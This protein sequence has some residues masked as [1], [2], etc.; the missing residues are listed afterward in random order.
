MQKKTWVVVS[1]F[2]RSA[3]QKI[4]NCNWMLVGSND[5]CLYTFCTYW[6]KFPN[7]CY[8]KGRLGIWLR[9]FFFNLLNSEISFVLTFMNEYSMFRVQ[10]KSKSYLNKLAK[11]SWILNIQLYST[12]VLLKSKACTKSAKNVGFPRNII[13]I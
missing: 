11:H 1:I 5:L 9:S 7:I 6:K 13:G 4:N 3:E 10:M 8:N 2:D 12:Y